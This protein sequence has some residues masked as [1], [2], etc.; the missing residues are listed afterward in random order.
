MQITKTRVFLKISFS[1]TKPERELFIF[2]NTF[3]N[4]LIISY[5]IAGV[6][7]LFWGKMPIAGYFRERMLLL[8]ALQR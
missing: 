7:Y 8:A 4:Q 1:A 2:D 6:G 3:D 5:I